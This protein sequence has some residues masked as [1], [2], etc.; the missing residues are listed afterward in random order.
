MKT[1]M[2]SWRDVTTI[3][4]PPLLTGAVRMTASGAPS[5]VATACALQL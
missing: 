5:T 1:A 3:A 4:I 2:C